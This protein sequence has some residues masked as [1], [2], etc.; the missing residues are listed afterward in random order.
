MANYIALLQFT[1]QGIRNIQETTRRST[2]VR[3]LATKLGVK[4]LD[5]FWTMGGYD[6]VMVLE[7]AG[8]ETVTAFT[9]KLGALGSIKSQTLRAFRAQEMDAILNKIK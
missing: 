4:V 1:E 6:V 9:L 2:A 7:A 3:E 8:D 5:I